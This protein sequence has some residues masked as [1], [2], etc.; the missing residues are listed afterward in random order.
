MT[1]SEYIEKCLGVELLDCQK[2]MINELEKSQRNRKF[3]LVYP[4]KLGRTYF[5]HLYEIG[6]IIF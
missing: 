2:N 3:Y 5:K 4:P 6:K 1:P